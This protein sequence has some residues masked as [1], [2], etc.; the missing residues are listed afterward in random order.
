MF[1]DQLLQFLV[2]RHPGMVESRRRLEFIQKRFDLAVRF[3]GF[4]RGVARGFRLLKDPIDVQVF[5]AGMEFQFPLEL[6]EEPMAF[7]RVRLIEAA[8]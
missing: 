1:L 2:F 7:W 8:F 3:Q 6:T 5:D 4:M